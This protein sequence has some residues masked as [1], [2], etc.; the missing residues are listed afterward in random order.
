L[1]CPPWSR[2]ED[3]ASFVDGNLSTACFAAYLSDPQRAVL[4][5]RHDDRIIGYAMLIRGVPDDANIQRAVP[6]RPAVEVSKLYLLPDFHGQGVSTALMDAALATATEWGARCLW[7]G[8]NE[9]N[10]RAHCFYAKSGFK[11]N[12]TKTFRMGAFVEDDHVMI[13]ELG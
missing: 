1:A 13:R 8:V 6:V 2:P 3:I 5:A 7:L 4:V 9:K 11:V 12:G 10:Q